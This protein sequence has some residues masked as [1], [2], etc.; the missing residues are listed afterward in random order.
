MHQTP[1][2]SSGLKLRDSIFN[3]TGDINPHGKLD[4]TSH[5]D[6][7]RV[8]FFIN[9]CIQLDFVKLTNSDHPGSTYL[10]G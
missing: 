4:L 2:Y 10:R 6:S 5:H 9:F 8:S 7:L 3:P 1:K